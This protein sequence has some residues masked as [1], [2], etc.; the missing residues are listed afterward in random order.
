MRS[1]VSVILSS[2]TPDPNM[3][4][5]DYDQTIHDHAALLVLVRHIGMYWV[6]DENNSAFR[7]NAHFTSISLQEKNYPS[8]ILTN[9][10]SELIKY[11]S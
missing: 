3:S 8:N 9:I 10:S 5:P 6:Y 4:R 11:Q 2:P 1:S 7:A